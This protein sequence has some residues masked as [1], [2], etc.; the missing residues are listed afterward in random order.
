MRGARRAR[1]RQRSGRQGPAGPAPWAPSSSRH[2]ARPRAPSPPAHLVLRQ[3]RLL[4]RVLLHALALLLPPHLLMFLRGG[5]CVAGQAGAA[6][7][8]VAGAACRR[9]RCRRPCTPS[10]L[11]TTI[12]PP[13]QH[14]PPAHDGRLL[15][16]RLE[17]GLLGLELRL[18]R[19]LLRL[20]LLKHLLGVRAVL[21]L[22][23]RLRVGR[24]PGGAVGGGAC[25]RRRQRRRPGVAATPCTCP[26][27][28]ACLGATLQGLRVEVLGVISR[29]GRSQARGAGQ[30]G[31]GGRPGDA[32]QQCHCGGRCAACVSARCNPYEGSLGE[33]VSGVR[34]G[35]RLAGLRACKLSPLRPC[36]RVS[37]LEA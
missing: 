24:Q 23:K 9:G 13:C 31:P 29:A 14:P 28:C 2:A 25:R 1:Q 21:D 10:R 4:L 3:L 7:R 32:A 22:A 17:L 33:P 20:D 30:Q 15:R 18:L 35:A 27:Q 8:S 36:F 6:S 37:L 11:P 34:G 12:A 16:L 5:R 26:R 19:G